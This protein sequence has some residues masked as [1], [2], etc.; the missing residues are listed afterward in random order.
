MKLKVYVSVVLFLAISIS[1]SQDNLHIIKY[2]NSS[3]SI[4]VDPYSFFPMQVGNF[5][6]YAFLNEIVREER[7]TKDSILE[8]NSKLYWINNLP[9]WTID[10]NYQ[11]FQYSP[12]DAEWSAL[13]FKLDADLGEEWTM[14]QNPYDSTESEIRRVEQIFQAE[15]LGINTSFK[16]VVQYTKFMDNGEYYEWLRFKYLLGAGLG[17]VN[18][19]ND[20]MPRPPE[21][22]L[23]AIIDGDTLGTIVGVQNDT[24]DYLPS[25]TKLFQN[26]PN[27]FNPET[28]ITYSLGLSGPTSLVIYNLLGERIETLI[29]Q[30]QSIGNYSYKL[31]LSGLPSGIYIYTLISGNTISSKKML[32]LK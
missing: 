32:Y 11:V 15:Y 27:P 25:S 3:D 5:W 20:E 14:W 26:Y 17:I 8:Y 7:V 16:E 28:I 9:T 10:T 12:S 4:D 30:Y 6:Q 29:N 18:I 24:D 1:Y 19:R 2:Y 23:S 22:L 31:N 21:Y 13:Y